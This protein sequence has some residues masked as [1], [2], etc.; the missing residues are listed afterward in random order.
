MKKRRK[1]PLQKKKEKLWELCKQVVRKRDG[2]VCVSCGATGLEGSNWHTGHLVPSS[3][4]GALLRYDLRNLG[5]QCYACN[6]NRGGNGAMY[7]R[8]VEKKYGKEMI[9]RLFKDKQKTVKCDT[10]F[11][12]DKLYEYERYLA[13]TKRELISITKGL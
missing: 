12:D 9:E 4:C 5:S 10:L 2:N 3:T 13:M 6:V 8:A 1:T 7:L 11:I